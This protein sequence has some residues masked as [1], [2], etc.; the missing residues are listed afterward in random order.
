VRPFAL[1]TAL[2][3]AACSEDPAYTCPDAQTT[4][5]GT[6]TLGQRCGWPAGDG[7]FEYAC[8]CAGTG[9][10]GGWMCHTFQRVGD[11]GCALTVPAG[12]A[13]C[14]DP[15]RASCF[16]NGVNGC[17][18]RCDCVPRLGVVT[19]PRWSCSQTCPP[20]AAVADVPAG[21]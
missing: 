20:D 7:G 11:G 18:F 4:L 16:Y 21:G 3:L 12:G 19:P 2:C 8:T 6:C 1:A 17:R 15:T 5:T 9:K 13:L 10:L 14:D